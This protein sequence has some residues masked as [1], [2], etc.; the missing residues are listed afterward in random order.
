VTKNSA[1]ASKP[2]ARPVAKDQ[3]IIQWHLESA[4]RILL[5]QL[6]IGR[7]S[8]HPVNQGS[9]REYFIRSFL[10]D[11]LG[12]NVGIGAGEIIDADSK[13]LQARNQHDIV[14]YRQSPK[15]ALGGGIDAFLVES[16]MA[17]IEVKS[18]LTRDDLATAI[19]AAAAV[20]RM[21][22]NLQLSSGQQA[23]TQRHRPPGIMSYL[24]AY[25]GPANMNTVYDWLA[26][27]HAEQGIKV[28]DLPATLGER[29]RIA[30]PS[31]DGIFVLGRG[32]VHFDNMRVTWIWDTVRAKD[33]GNWG[34]CDTELGSLLVLFL[35]LVATVGTTYGEWV[36]TVKYIGGVNL[37]D[38]LRP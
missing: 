13:I 17:T 10:R 4:E 15:I 25:A 32:F 9:A 5:E 8:G 38:R 33:K 3:G 23:E 26:D 36:D 34:V 7:S 2:I 22:S 21:K 1:S 16:V 28:P 37:L 35:Q 31:L 29:V 18:T 12:D 14:L 19:R 11:H 30:G 20:K 6:E 27:V 24:V